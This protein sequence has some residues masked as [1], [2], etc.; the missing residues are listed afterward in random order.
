MVQL[1]AFDIIFIIILIQASIGFTNGI[2]LFEEPA[3]ATPHNKVSGWNIS[4]IGNAT[5]DTGEG[6]TGIGKV[7]DQISTLAR[8]AWECLFIFLNIVLA[9]IYVYPTLVDTFNL[10]NELSVFLQIGIYVLYVWGFMQ[11]KSGKSTM[12][13]E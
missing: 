1:R 10:P 13:M 12:Y 7:Y 4:V 9:I 5:G 11:Y 2:G 8:W 6:K 3:Y